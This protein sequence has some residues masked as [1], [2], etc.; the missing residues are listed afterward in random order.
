MPSGLGPTIWQILANYLNTENP[1]NPLFW[2]RDDVTQRHRA[3]INAL[4][5]I[6]VGRGKRFGSNMPAAVNHLV[7]G[8]KLAWV[9]IVQTGQFFSPSFSGSD[10]SNTNTSGGRPDRLCNGNLSPDERRTTMLWRAP[11]LA[12]TTS[13]VG[14][15]ALR[16]PR[17]CAG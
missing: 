17:S 8:W 4:W 15:P 1:Y 7:G 16:S 6:P 3:V 12:I 9:T 14:R 10:P 5:E 11:S 13:S 2:N